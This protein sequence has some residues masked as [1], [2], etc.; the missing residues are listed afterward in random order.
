MAKPF[1]HVFRVRYAEVD[2]QRV[3][4]N[5][6]Y[7]EYADVLVTEFFRAR[8]AEGLYHE[9]EFH[10]RKAEVDYI[11]PIRF[12]ELIEGRLTVESVGNSSMVMRIALHGAEAAEGDLRAEIRLVQVHVDLATGK[13][14]RVPDSV[15]ASFG[16]AVEESAHG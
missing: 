9:L 4:F 3:V 12:D 5:S 1:T 14:L 13:P 16:F 8:R 10:A 11:Q 7:L 15:R 2:P 6:R